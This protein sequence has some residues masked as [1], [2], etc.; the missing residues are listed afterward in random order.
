MRSP[1]RT[2]SP[3][4]AAEPIARALTRRE[5]LRIG[6]V[7]LAGGV[8]AACGAG[9]APGSSGRPGSTA[10][11]TASAG[12]PQ[13]VPTPGVS[14]AT[15]AAAAGAGSGSL[16]ML[17]RPTDRSVGLSLLPVADGPMYVE[18]GDAAGAYA[19]RTATVEATAGEPLQF[20]L[21]GLAAGSRCQ[22]RVVERAGVGADH[23]FVTKR[24]PGEGF[25]FTIDADP[26]YGD[27]NFDGELYDVTLENV[28]A[29][30][31]DFHVNLGDTFMTDKLGHPS[32]DQVV[33]TYTGIRQHLG[34]I[35]ADAPLFLVNGN[36]DGE[37]G[38]ERDG[39][40]D[41]LAVVCTRARQAHYPC[42]VPGEFYTGSTVPEPI[43]GIRDAWYAWTWGDALFIVLDPYWYTSPKP[44]SGTD[45]NWG[46]TLGDEQYAWLQ[47]TLE[48]SEAAHRFVF[49]HQL[50]GGQDKDGRGGIEAA[51]M[52]EWGGANAD[53][54]AGFATH[55]P[56]WPAPIHQLLVAN[57]VSA[58][59]HGHDHVFVHQVLDG[60]VYQACAQPS[61]A[62]YGNTG[63]ASQY[64]YQGDV[65]SS[66]G[67]VR[68]EVSPG[69]ARVEY[70]R[71]YR[72]RDETP[73]RGNRAVAFAYTV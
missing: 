9:A 57:H 27:P 48:G 70:V 50:V 72:Q 52:Y 12:T 66:S 5:F 39:T 65:A 32:A 16:P 33:A 42:P 11:A 20:T 4:G 3:R 51:G 44:G 22:Y 14:P 46:W 55:R 54:S 7:G 69:S 15:S 56:G 60:V 29:D 43:T 45:R 59:F 10:A 68:V 49:T 64:G 6:A 17:G 35:G 19:A 73:D 25:V 31:P 36:H 53:G 71:A 67:H 62:R 13:P 40:E 18:Y 61:L 34:L 47:R 2:P 24:A 23:A 1:T 37:S 21:E 30:T 58:V 28:L 38:W 41:A 63:L 8:V 26:H